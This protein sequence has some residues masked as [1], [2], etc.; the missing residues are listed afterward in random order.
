MPKKL[1]NLFIRQIALVDAG[2][3]QEAHI[4]LMKRA[5]QSAATGTTTVVDLT[6][7]QE[8]A[9]VAETTEKTAEDVVTITTDL[10]TAK[11]EHDR[12]EADLTKAR[13]DMK[14]ALD[15]RT[16]ELEDAKAEVLKINKQRRR[17]RFIKLAHELKN[18][19]GTMGDD[20]GETLDTIEKAMGSKDFTK[21]YNRL[22][23]WNTVIEK[24]N[25]LMQEIGAVEGLSMLSGP[26]AQL[27]ALTAEK[28]SADPKLSRAKAYA[29]VLRENPGLY[30][31][32]RDELAKK[33]A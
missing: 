3:N 2:A 26:E 24:G 7:T 18:L 27:E 15:V 17:E 21:F 4:A 9:T 22:V 14:A 20:F 12:I 29:A 11:S 6:K 33:G 8:K 31:K 25:V 32:Y 10:A 19:P 5:T 30:R 16:K 23:S 1:T 13:D 28:M